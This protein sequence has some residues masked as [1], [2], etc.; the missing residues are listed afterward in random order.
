MGGGA[1]DRGEVLELKDEASRMSLTQLP[2]EGDSEALLQAKG[3]DLDSNAALDSYSHAGAD[4][5]VDVLGQSITLLLRFEGGSDGGNLL[6]EGAE[7]VLGGWPNA[8]SR[9]EDK[10]GELHV[11]SQEAGAVVVLAVLLVLCSNDG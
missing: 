8:T 5:S 11:V 3:E 6:R 7:V 4:A 2:S 9:G 10:G 1:G